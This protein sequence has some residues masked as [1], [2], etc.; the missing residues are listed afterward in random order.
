MLVQVAR[1]G[2]T[3][4]AS[5]SATTWLGLGPAEA[6]GRHVRDLLGVE[7]WALA[8]PRVELALSGVPQQ[9]ERALELDGR[10]VQASMQY[11]PREV[12]GLPDGFYL[13]VCD[14]TRRARAEEGLRVAA[15]LTDDVLQHLFATGL[16]VRRLEGRAEAALLADLNARLQE[17]TDAMRRAVTSLSGRGTRS[18]RGP[19]ADGPRTVQPGT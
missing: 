2:R 9:L 5:T 7:H 16:A 17:T 14:V 10:L 13:L 11:L 4:F 12:D 1:D 8:A 6:Q 19:V 18:A 3:V 15:R